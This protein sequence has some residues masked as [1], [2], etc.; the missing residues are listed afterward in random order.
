MQ[1]KNN[2]LFLLICCVFFLG[3]ESCSIL[4]P[5]QSS[6]GSQTKHN[7]SLDTVEKLEIGKTLINEAK[8]IFGTPDMES[9]LE[10]FKNEIGLIYFFKE[11]KSTRLGLSFYKDTGILNSISWH[12]NRNDPE[13]ILDVALNRY[14]SHRFN[15]KWYIGENPHIFDDEIHYIDEEKGP[16]IVYKKTDKVVVSIN[17]SD[18]KRREIARESKPKGQMYCI[19]K[20]CSPARKD[21]YRDLEN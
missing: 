2:I 10:D 9:T 19:D 1:Q 7:I 15:K 17:W 14:K 18:D 6:I 8:Q 4:K 11:E 13:R 5:K 12:T 16:L 3:L 20:I 21:P